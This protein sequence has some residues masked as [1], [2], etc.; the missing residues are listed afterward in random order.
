MMV[1][2]DYEAF[3]ATPVATDPYRHVVVP[4]FVPAREL[5]EVVRD[6]P[7]MSRGGS[8]PI[9]SIK[10]GPKAAELIRE[11]EGPTFRDAVAGKFGLDLGGAPTM[12]TLR[13]CSTERDGRIHCDSRTKRV[14]MLLYLNLDQ[15]SWDRQEGCLR[16]LRGP[17]DIDDYVVEVP[18]INGTML[19]FPNGPDTWHGYRR[20]IGRRYAVQLNYM[21][22]DRA[23]RSELRRH[24][25]SAFIKRLTTAA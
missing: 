18:P 11:L 23:A 16:L 17:K 1:R 22:A 4:G 19:V 7:V 10:L 8:F 2:L 3:R 24:R 13:G 21:T 14:T 6:L 12:V 9:A 15:G 20:F 5:A 25:I